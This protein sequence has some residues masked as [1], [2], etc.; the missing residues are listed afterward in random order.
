[1]RLAE[2]FE[3]VVGPDAPVH[4][5]AYDGST[6]GDPRSDVAIVVRHPAAVNYIVLEPGA[7]GLTRA[8]VA[9]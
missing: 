9:G 2:V 1:M 7:L 5:R 4:F 8:Y 3:R 6:A